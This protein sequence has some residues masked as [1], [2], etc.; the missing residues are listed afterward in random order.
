[1][2]TNY[3]SSLQDALKKSRPD[4]GAPPV[5][6]TP[7]RSLASST[8]SFDGSAVKASYASVTEPTICHG[9]KSEVEIP[10]L[11]DG[12]WELVCSM[13]GNQKSTASNVSISIG[14]SK[15]ALTI[16]GPSAH[17]RFKVLLDYGVD[18][19]E[20]IDSPLS[21]KFVEVLSTDGQQDATPSLVNLDARRWSALN[22]TPKGSNAVRST[23]PVPIRQVTNAV[24][25]SWT[26]NSSKAKNA[27]GRHKSANKNKF[28][29]I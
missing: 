6:P 18:E 25:H 13:K 8:S 20:I 10:S 14:S 4:H 19:S 24:S 2:K 12:S 17:N 22:S 26:A 15:V 7:S 23:K 29:T 1:M 3:S 21:D 5:H 9:S 27:P 28:Q 11:E 16:S